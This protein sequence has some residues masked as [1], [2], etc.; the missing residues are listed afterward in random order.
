MTS[1]VSSFVSKPA[2]G[3]IKANSLTVKE[4]FDP[5]KFKEYLSSFDANDI[6]L[7]NAGN[8]RETIIALYLNAVVALKEGEYI[9]SFGDF[10]LFNIDTNT[11]FECGSFSI[12]SLL[13]EF[14]NFT[15]SYAPIYTP[16]IAN[17]TLENLIQICQK[18]L[19]LN[20]FLAI[21]N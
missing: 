6:V 3:T 8:P 11:S 2:Y 20:E 5:I 15:Y 17:F 1:I 18:N 13:S 9:T 12:P 7:V 10:C 21:Q 14:D 19:R 4:A 16:V